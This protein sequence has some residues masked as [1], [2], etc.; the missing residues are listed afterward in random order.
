MRQHVEEADAKH[1]ACHRGK[2]ELEAAVAKP[3]QA[4]QESPGERDGHDDGR[5]ENE[6]VGR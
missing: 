2:D 3:Q 6:E 4:R 1:D 5:V